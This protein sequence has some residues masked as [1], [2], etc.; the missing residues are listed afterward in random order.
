MGHSGP[1]DTKQLPVI[2]NGDVVITPWG[3][4]EVRPG[5]LIYLLKDQPA[6]SEQQFYRDYNKP[7]YTK[8]P[9]ILPPKD[10]LWLRLL[11][12]IGLNPRRTQDMT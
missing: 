6:M 5:E 4:R 9:A 1:L 11:K 8:Q 12:A 2:I 3:E 7:L 10:P